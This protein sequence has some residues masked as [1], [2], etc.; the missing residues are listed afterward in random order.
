MF[1]YGHFRL[2]GAPSASTVWVLLAFTAQYGD[3]VSPLQGW[4]NTALIVFIW[5]VGGLV[6]GILVYLV[7]SR[8][9]CEDLA[10]FLLWP[11][12]VL[13]FRAYVGAC[14]AC[15]AVLMAAIGVPL[16]IIAWFASLESDSS[17]K[18]HAELERERVDR[19]PQPTGAAMVGRKDHRGT[20]DDAAAIPQW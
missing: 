5:M 17:R 7:A 18:R 1:P 10:R 13:A 15:F 3:I 6:A 8:Y 4:A 12:A 19:E 2:I 14:S 20:H 16:G 11:L 9:G